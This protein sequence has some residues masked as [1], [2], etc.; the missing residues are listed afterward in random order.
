MKSCL[1]SRQFFCICLRSEECPNEK[2][3]EI[4]RSCRQNIYGEASFDEF[5]EKYAGYINVLD[6]AIFES[7]G[8]R[9]N[10]GSNV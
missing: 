8:D 7:P 4:V 9:V 5:V 1:R 10:S 2:K 6:R 3:Y